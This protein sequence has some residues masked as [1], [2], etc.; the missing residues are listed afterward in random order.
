MSDIHARV[1]RIMANLT[2][3]SLQ[4]SMPNNKYVG[5]HHDLK[6]VEHPRISYVK[7]S[8]CLIKNI[9]MLHIVYN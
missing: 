6:L 4:R 2:E 9:I 8:N 5:V 3:A 1:V 7:K